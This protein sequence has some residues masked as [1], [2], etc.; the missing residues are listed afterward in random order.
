MRWAYAVAAAGVA[1]LGVGGALAF[2]N[3]GVT[4]LLAIVSALAAALL[5]GL[6]VHR[7]QAP[8]PA[9]AERLLGEWRHELAQGEY[10]PLPSFRDLD[11]F[12]AFLAEKNTLHETLQAGC[13][14]ARERVLALEV[15]T[16]RL[17]QAC[18]ESRHS[19]TQAQSALSHWLSI[20]RISSRDAYVR[21]REQHETALRESEALA[22][23]LQEKA[24]ARGL[25]SLKKQTLA[26]LEVQASG[27]LPSRA[28]DPETLAG[29]FRERQNLERA[30]ARLEERE[31]EALRERSEVFG[32]VRGSLGRLTGEIVAIEE[33]LQ[34]LRAREQDLLDERQSAALALEICRRIQNDSETVFADLLQRVGF[35][36]EKI[37]NN[38]RDV[39]LNAPELDS[40]N[41][42]AADSGGTVRGLDQLSTG[43]RDSLTLSLRLALA[44]RSAGSAARRLL[45]L[46]D[47]LLTLDRARQR[48]ALERL[49]NFQAD[50]HWQILLFTKERELLDMCSE[51]FGQRLLVQE[52]GETVEPVTHRT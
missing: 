47:P 50:G 1:I 24:G 21:A 31:R 15:Q 20:R 11:E 4:A 48:R 2:E 27:G 10:G 25:E 30:L 52:L 23:R 49:S 37:A 9:A 16:D 44:E 51:I 40:A 45:V 35:G 28:P 6:A 3:N 46:D 39:A 36:F 5:G 43:T 14:E 38:S 17:K 32:E 18:E 13:T 41:L 8:D 7:Q 42:R 29:L 26:D 33:A 22:S 19:F 34:E 12:R